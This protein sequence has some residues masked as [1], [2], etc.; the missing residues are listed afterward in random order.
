MGENDLWSIRKTVKKGDY[1]YAIVPEHPRA[2]INGYVLEHIV[3]LEN[4]IGR[5][6]KEGEEVH[7]INENK[8]DNSPDNLLLVKKGEHQRQH[9]LKRY[10][11][12]R[13]KVL[14]T[15]AFCKTKFY[16]FKNLVHKNNKAHFCSKKCNGK[17]YHG[18]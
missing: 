12:G 17:F 16:R 5:L 7:H 15:C 4:K 6:L 2:T 9:M 14:L 18:K 8:K 1:L 11:N 10:P 13:E 3:V